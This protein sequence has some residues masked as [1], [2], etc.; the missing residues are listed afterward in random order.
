MR[1]WRAR[2]GQ[3]GGC[4]LLALALLVGSGAG[5]AR[6]EEMSAERKVFWLNTAAMGTIVTWGV[7]NWDYGQR[8]PN[9]RSEGWFGRETKSGGADKLGHLY[10]AYLVSHLFSSAYR[11]W[12][13]PEETANRMGALSSLG[14][15]TLME[16]GDSFSPFGFAYEDMVVNVLGAGLGY[17]FDRSPELRRKI[18]LRLEYHPRFTG[19][20]ETD[21]VTDYEHFKY[22]V[23]I[24]AAGFDAIEHP[25][26]QALELHLGYY[27]RGFE[28]F[29]P[30]TPDQRQR[31]L[32][33][34]IGL[35]LGHLLKPLWQTRLFDYLQLPY[36]YLDLRQHLDD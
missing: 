5:P 36:T 16:V 24:K 4:L 27:T 29:S 20:F 35:N 14:V 8:T 21:L 25:L 1:G 28:D 18:D 22:L 2:M 15:T 33:A 10:T 26:L 6:A 32:Y 12:D 11:A 34:G 19:E 31:T 30:G 9:A 7:I 3:R 17:A 13:Y 23:A